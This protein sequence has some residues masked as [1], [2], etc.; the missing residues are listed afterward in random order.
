MQSKDD[1]TTAPAFGSALELK[2]LESTGR[3]TGY[4]SVFDVV[5]SQRDCVRAGAFRRS[6][7]KRDMPVQL[8]WQHQWESPIGVIEKLFEDKHGLYVQGSLLMDVARAREAYALLKAG[9]LRGLSIGYQPKKTRRDPDSGARELLEVDLWEVSIVTL[10]A[11]MQAQV[12]VVKQALPAGNAMACL[13]QA[14][15]RAEQVLVRY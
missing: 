7:I 6:L 1:H 3:F 10:P 12:T 15:T 4:A 9:A 13:M 14:L 2:S 5:D 11:N 8:L